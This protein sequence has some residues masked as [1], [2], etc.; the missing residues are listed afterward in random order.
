MNR[1]HEGEVGQCLK[2]E[3][4]AAKLVL[5]DCFSVLQVKLVE[6]VDHRLEGVYQ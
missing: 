4:R 2:T 3:T 6:L 5:V 1:K